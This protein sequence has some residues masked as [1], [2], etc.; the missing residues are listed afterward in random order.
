MDRD[1]K[2]GERHDDRLDRDEAAK[3]AARERHDKA[4]S[5][6]EDESPGA[7]LHFGSAG[8]GGAE[9]EQIPET[10]EEP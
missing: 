3:D 10:D 7:R 6:A 2:D 4:K 8:S 1:R 9:Y 5:H